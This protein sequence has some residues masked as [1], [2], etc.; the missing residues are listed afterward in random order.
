MIKS[1]VLISLFVLS[2]CAV[3][4]VR[5]QDLEVGVFGGGSY[6]MGELNPGKQFFFTQ[7]TFGGV[8]RWNFDERWALKINGLRGKLA[9]DDAVS[10]VNEMRNL[11]FTS[12][13]TEI[14]TVIEFNFFPYF[15]GSNISYFT[16][17]LF[18]GP[19][20]FIFKPEAE[21]NG[22]MI[23]LRDI[24]TEGQNINGDKYSLYG[25]AF[26]FGMGFKYSVNNRLGLGIEWGLRKTY[27]DYI[28]DISTTYY[29]DFNQIDPDDIGAA[30]FLSDPSSVKHEPGMQRGN[31]QNND[32]YSIAGFTLTYRFSIGEKSTCA[33]FENS[34]N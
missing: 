4:T 31:S 5:S 29:I 26:A 10:K 32:W 23:S 7:P 33:D 18:V 21:F 27:T 17:F 14:S 19:D 16:P 28:D 11:R 13:F 34:K 25:F 22:E 3:T 20:F 24:G 2:L 12:S 1:K 8:L 30:E 15:T 9:G 6:Y